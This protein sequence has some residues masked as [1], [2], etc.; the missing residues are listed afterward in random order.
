MIWIGIDP[1]KRGGYAWITNDGEYQAKPWDDNKFVIDMY[2]LQA[3]K[4][5]ICACVEKVAA[6]PKNGAVSMFNF[7]KSAGFIEGVLTALGIPYQLVPPR[8][9]KKEF[10]L[11]HDKAESIEVCKRLLPGIDLLPNEKCRVESDGMAEAALLSAYAKR[12]F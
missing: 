2:E 1:G 6:M 8:V 5:G 3:R 11:G 9:W 12:H 4:D 7:G 10:S